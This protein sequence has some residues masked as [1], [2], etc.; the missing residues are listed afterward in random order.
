MKP[1]VK[2][3]LLAGVVAAE[4]VA[5][6]LAWRDLRGRSEEQIRGTKVMWRAAILANP[7]NSLVYWILGRRSPE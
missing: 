6:W 3:P 2:M 5:A 7:G 4:L 1:N